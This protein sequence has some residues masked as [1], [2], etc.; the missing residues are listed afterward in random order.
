MKTIKGNIVDVVNK[1]IFKGEIYFTNKIE[2]IVRKNV[3]ENQFI[4]PGFVNAHVH[5]ESSMLCPSEFSKQVVKHGTVA[6]VTDPHEIANVLGVKGINFMINDAE[7]GP[8]KVFFGAPSCVP[9]T[10]F[11]TSG[12]TINSDEIKRLLSK[13]EIYFLS[14]MMNFPGVIFN[15]TEVNAKLKLAKY[16]NKPIDGHAP[17]LKGKD[18][19]KYVSSGISADHE[20]FDISEAFEKIKLGMKIQIREGSAAK[21][22]E[23]LYPL[24][25]SH[26]DM[27]MFCTDDSHPDDLINGHINLIAKKAFAKKLNYFNILRACSYNPVKHYNLPVG[28]LQTNDPADF[29]VANNKFFSHIISVYINGDDK[30]NNVSSFK[31][32]LS[33]NNFNTSFINKK[34]ISFKNNG[35]FCNVIS[36][37]DGELITKR[38]R[39]N[40]TEVF[41]KDDKLKSGFNKI[42]VKNRYN[43]SAKPIIGIVK[44]FNI[45]TGA[46]ASTIAHDSHNIISIGASDKEIIKAINIVIKTKGGISACNNNL[47]EILPL[48]IAGLMTSKNGNWVA[49]K[50]KSISDFAKT[51]L[52]STLHAPFMTMS[53]LALLV[54]PELKIGD[55]GLFDI[56]TLQFVNL[57]EN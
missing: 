37:L 15:D 56:R 2:K 55:K 25:D 20:C 9:A 5:I 26:P 30:L 48:E 18:L 13:K 57:F 17:G 31:S 14:E 52:G 47:S 40:Y 27:V 6:V 11:E 19:K 38:E 7:N 10:S 49:K 3:D 32:A 12:C 53:F 45:K 44:N 29:V 24:I 54:I 16:F 36:V 41:E 21:N 34:D 22:F 1:E 4:L 51:K 23:A 42:V 35:N 39:L 8:V 33:P 28:L 43:K 46:I 50:Y